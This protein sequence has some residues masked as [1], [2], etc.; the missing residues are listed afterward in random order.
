[1]DVNYHLNLTMG[2]SN[3]SKLQDP[4]AIFEFLI[5]NPSNNNSVDKPQENI[6]ESLKDTEKFC[7]EFNH[8]EL[9]SFFD[10]IELIQQQLDQLN[11]T[12]KS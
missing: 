3:L 11:S 12:T 6:P 10:N 4:T 9:Y 5:K 1:M 8:K 2:Q 7:I